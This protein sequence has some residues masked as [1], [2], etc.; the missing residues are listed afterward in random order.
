LAKMWL[1]MSGL[2]N[3]QLKCD[4]LTVTK[5]LTNSVSVVIKWSI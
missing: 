2:V 5:M 3:F 4:I 1:M